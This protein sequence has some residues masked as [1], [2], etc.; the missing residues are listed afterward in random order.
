VLSRPDEQK[1][2]R[3]VGVTNEPRLTLEEIRQAVR[4]KGFS[5]LSVPRELECVREIPLLG[6]GKVNHR[7]LARMLARPQS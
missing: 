7:E 6:T 2:E 4:A 1:G 3:L 5:N